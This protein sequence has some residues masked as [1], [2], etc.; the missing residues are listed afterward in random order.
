MKKYYSKRKNIQ[1][2]LKQFKVIWRRRE[3][4]CKL[5]TEE[6]SGM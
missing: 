6:K 3:N 4:K 1:I 5:T 2:E